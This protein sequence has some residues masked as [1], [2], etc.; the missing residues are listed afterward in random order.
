M[1]IVTLSKNSQ[2]MRKD[3]NHNSYPK[4]IH[5]LVH[6]Y[7]NRQLNL[8]PGFQRNSVWT[9]K[10]RAKLIESVI[11]NYPVP[12]IFLYRREKNGKIV[13]DVIDGKQRLESILMFMGVM[14]G[15]RFRVK[16]Q[17]E[18]NSESIEFGWNYLKR[19][20]RQSS[21]EGY[22]LYTIEV[23]GDL[24]DIIDLFVRI[25]STGKA[26]TSAEKQH[27]KYYNSSFLKTA[28]N[29]AEKYKDYFLRTGILSAGQISRMK[30]VE[31][32]CE[33]M[34]SIGSDDVINKKAALD[35]IMGKGLTAVQVNKQKTKVVRVLNRIKTTFPKLQETRFR[36]L[37]DF[38]VLA[39]LISKYEDEG[40]ILTDKKR[41]KLAWNLLK[42]FSNGVDRTRL[43]QKKVEGVD[44]ADSVYREYLL[45]VLQA[46]DE[47]SQRRKRMTI[48]DNL[49]RNIFAIK[50]KQR[51]F[52]R[53]QRRIIWNST[54][55][56]KCQECGEVL[57]W[58]DFTIDHIDPH[59]KGGRSEIENASLMC[60]KH[61]SAKG[62]RAV[63]RKAA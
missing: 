13:Y 56:R 51:G 46:T 31:L 62:N 55:E 34:L 18:E 38:Y 59:S 23:D 15:N 35:K 21:I 40:L 58:D 20:N 63:R 41:N 61:N 48:I 4:P 28:A 17:L 10:D 24:S 26:L 11:R 60:R 37:S 2:Q 50:D 30:H 49:I 16:T 52:T 54:E 44:E 9:T 53:E 42:E 3:L 25:N 39:I 43:K 12:A 29:V 45:T 5:D 32:L 8:N 7:N 14:R 19:K 47:I 22:K 27:A 6:L 1:V 36:Q 57:T 33:I